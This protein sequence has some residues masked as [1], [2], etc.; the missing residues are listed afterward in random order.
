MTRIM[1][2]STTATD[3]PIAGTDIAAG[4]INGNTAWSIKDFARFPVHATIDVNGSNTGADI[5]DV[6]IG[7]AS[8][9]TAVSWV[10]AKRRAQP[11][12]YPP[13]IYCN[14]STL[15]SLFNAMASHSLK[16]VTDF[17]LWIATLDGT[18]TVADMTGVTAIQ[19]AG[20]AQTHHHYDESIVYD[21]HWIASSAPVVKT[22]LLVQKDFTSKLIH[23][24][25]GITWR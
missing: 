22:A 12:H 4:Y 6:E 1:R 19:Y 8:V 17:R 18:K 13:I 14:R 24:S 21:N 3:I 5:L 2:D 23:S 20:E 10:S 15:T 7:D 9:S 16:I 11:S 25:D